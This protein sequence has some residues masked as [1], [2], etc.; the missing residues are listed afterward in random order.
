MMILLIRSFIYKQ[1]F[2][3]IFLKEISQIQSAATLFHLF[4]FGMRG[5]V[6]MEDASIIAAIFTAVISMLHLCFYI[7]FESSKRNKK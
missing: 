4:P 2:G 7:F 5:G 6:A 1:K 3:K